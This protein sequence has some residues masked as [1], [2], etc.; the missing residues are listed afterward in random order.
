VVGEPAAEVVARIVDSAGVI[1]GSASIEEQPDGT[2]RARLESVRNLAVGSHAGTLR[3]QVCA[4][5]ACRTKYGDQP[6]PYVFSVLSNE[7]LT[8]LTPLP[9][10]SDWTTFQGNA[11]HTAYVPVTLDPSRFSSR[12]L[13]TI[14]DSRSQDASFAVTGDGK[15]YFPSNPKSDSVPIAGASRLY[16]LNETDGSPAWQFSGPADTV[17]LSPAAAAE[18]RVYVTTAQSGSN[19][20]L[21]SLV[22]SNGSTGY[23][24]VYPGYDSGQVLMPEYS[25]V[26]VGGLLRALTRQPVEICCSGGVANFVQSAAY[27]LATGEFRWGSTAYPVSAS[28]D[29]SSDFLYGQ[30]GVEPGIRKL[31]LAT[32][33]ELAFY[34][35]PADSPSSAFLSPSVVAGSSP[36]VVSAVGDHLLSLNADSGTINWSKPIDRFSTDSVSYA[37]GLV[38]VPSGGG[39]VTAFGLKTGT[40]LWSWTAPGPSGSEFPMNDDLAQFVGEGRVI[41]APIITD[42]LMFLS[43]NLRV[44]AVDL[45]TRS[46]R[47]VYPHPGR[48]SLSAN[49]ILYINR[50]RIGS[51]TL[52]SD[53]TVAAINLR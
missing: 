11:A 39:R 27:D 35:D 26:V 46:T 32:G 20:S 23:Q 41:G 6:L 10:A 25:P 37:E 34:A 50:I 22:A 31:D 52:E 51:D 7:N 43:T 5:T 15:L 33:N 21:W 16:A 9:G 17:Y 1:A 38:F 48:L 8:T 2:Y 3:V 14:A 36:E 49:G 13:R 45:A 42:N 47:W 28:T 30:S 18:G 40:E 19:S 53:G 24:I 44:Y 29:G 4:D 12:W